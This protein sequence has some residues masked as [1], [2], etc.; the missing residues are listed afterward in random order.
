ME[1]IIKKKKWRFHCNKHLINE[2]GKFLMKKIE[3]LL[4]QCNF[5]LVKYNFTENKNFFT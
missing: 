4:I 1:S 3:A 2:I 5:G